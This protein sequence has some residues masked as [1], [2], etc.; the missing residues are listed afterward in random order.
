MEKILLVDDEVNVLLA[1]QRH[2]RGLY[3]VT[4]AKSG[5]EGLSALEEQGPFA[6][7]V[8]DYCMPGMDGIQFLSLAHRLKPDTVRLML[9]G[10]ADLENAIKAVNEG[11]I[12]RFL[13][14]PCKSEEFKIALA[15]AV[16]QYKL[17]MAERELLEK[18]LKG[19]IKVLTD[20]LSILSPYVCLKD[21][22]L[23][24]MAKKLAA[25]LN[26]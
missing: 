5:D 22:Y 11:N 6:V 16:E 3:K 1:Y 17:V 12:F 10:Y 19:S 21:S 18:T 20:I 2:V 15:A 7:V 14:K 4:L 8:S 9:T 23:S 25:R 24:R 13:T 26:V